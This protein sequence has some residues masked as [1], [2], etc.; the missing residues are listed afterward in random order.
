MLSHLNSWICSY[1]PSREG[2]NGRKGRI[3]IT[4]LPFAIFKLIE[5][6]K[7]L[8][9]GCTCTNNGRSSSS[10]VAKSSLLWL[11]V[12][13]KQ[14]RDLLFFFF[15]IVSPVFWV[16]GFHWGKVK[17]MLRVMFLWLYILKETSFRHF[18]FLFRINILFWRRKIFVAR[19]ESTARKPF[20]RDLCP[21][22]LHVTLVLAA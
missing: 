5:C 2:G 15:F 7:D 22:P 4:I 1:L 13:D 12:T 3:R 8:R 14:Q 21:L 19:C 20:V 9:C 10:F 11:R 18:I 17:V 6:F 16:D